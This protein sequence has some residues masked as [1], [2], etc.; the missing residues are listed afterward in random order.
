MQ[1]MICAWLVAH[2]A[3]VGLGRPLGTRVDK[4]LAGLARPADGL[5]LALVDVHRLARLVRPR[6]RFAHRSILR[7]W[8]PG[9]LRPPGAASSRPTAGAAP[10]KA[11]SA[12]A[13]QAR[14]LG[15]PR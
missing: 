2:D 6:R 14:R 12:L 11:F 13:R 4:H 5:P 8:R 3:G 9:T 10:L 1:R 7:C 15:A